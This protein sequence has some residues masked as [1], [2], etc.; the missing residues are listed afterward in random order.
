MGTKLIIPSSILEKFR[1]SDDN[2]ARLK[3]KYQYLIIMERS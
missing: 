2:I 3:L 1:I